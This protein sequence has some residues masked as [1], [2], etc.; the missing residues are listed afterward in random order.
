MWREE[1]RIARTTDSVLGP[2]RWGSRFVSLI[3]YNF[4]IRASEFVFWRPAK[5]DQSEIEPFSKYLR[6]LKALR[7]WSTITCSTVQCRRSQGCDTTAFV[8]NWM[9]NRCSYP[10]IKIA[11]FVAESLVSTFENFQSIFT[12][13]FHVLVI[14]ECLFEYHDF[15]PNTLQIRLLLSD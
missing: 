7:R 4:I 12:T 11:R 6:L 2:F 14:T 3:D 1:N 5:I 13:D 10:D 15:K 8:I 9:I